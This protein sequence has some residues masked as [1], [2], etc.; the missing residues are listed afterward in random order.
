MQPI[1]QLVASPP[2]NASSAGSEKP[3]SAMLAPQR[4]FVDASGES[5]AWTSPGAPDSL[6]ILQYPND[7][8]AIAPRTI[9]AV[10]LIVR[11]EGAEP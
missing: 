10:D 5:I 8:A 4:R 9:L 3:S 6:L 2:Q 1:D 11:E 7:P